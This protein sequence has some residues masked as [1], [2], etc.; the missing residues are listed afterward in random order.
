MYFI[1]WRE[2]D[3]RLCLKCFKSLQV[4]YAKLYAVVCTTLISSCWD[5]KQQTRS[6]SNLIKAV[7]IQHLLK[8]TN[9]QTKQTTP[10]NPAVP[11]F[12]TIAS[13]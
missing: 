1:P 5:F 8:Q 12:P 6:L 9:K 4:N 11:L 13:S 2:T 3:L 7:E 10:Q